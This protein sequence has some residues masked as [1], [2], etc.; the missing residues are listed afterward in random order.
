[1]KRL[2]S[3]K[4]FISIAL[5]FCIVLTL[6]QTA[7]GQEVAT[8][9][10]K[11]VSDLTELIKVQDRIASALEKLVEEDTSSVDPGA[12]TKAAIISNETVP[13][14]SC[15]DN[16]TTWDSSSTYK[17]SDWNLDFIP[18]EKYDSDQPESWYTDEQF[19]DLNGDGLSDYIYKYS[20]YINAYGNKYTNDQT[21]VYL[22]NGSGFDVAYRCVA[23]VYYAPTE[24]ESY[25][26][27][28]ADM[29]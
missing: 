2:F 16:H 9:V 26:G 25:Y 6:S 27:D 24:S 14:P 28:C 19:V 23:D 4:L 17:T 7:F 21:C 15:F 20:Y 10:S 12:T 8:S 5:L 11:K 13:N 1:M 3:S 29:S 18:R 22:N